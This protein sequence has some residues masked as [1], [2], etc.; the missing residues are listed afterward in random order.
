MEITAQHFY[1]EITEEK[2]RTRDRIKPLNIG[3]T[4]TT[5][6]IGE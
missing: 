4:G 1:G 5:L 2:I 6:R 3:H